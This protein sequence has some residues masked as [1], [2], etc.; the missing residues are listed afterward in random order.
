MSDLGMSPH[1]VENILNH[2]SGFR[3]GVV[4]T[5]NKSVYER[6]TR[7][8]LLMWSEHIEGLISGQP[9]NVVALRPAASA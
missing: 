7:T 5:Y 3:R 2:R 6:E 4:G 1:I 8:A 9:T